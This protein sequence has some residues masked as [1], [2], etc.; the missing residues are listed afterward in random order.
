MG[1]AG[2]YQAGERH[3]V[4]PAQSLIIGMLDDI[5]DQGI[6]NG[7]EAVYRIIYNFSFTHGSAIIFNEK[8][9]RAFS[10]CKATIAG[11]KMAN[12]ECIDVLFNGCMAE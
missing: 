4:D 1:G 6:I 7:N 8:L 11:A 10:H 9:K 12:F 3:L 2:I 5:K